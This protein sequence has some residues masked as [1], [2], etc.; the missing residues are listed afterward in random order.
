MKITIRGINYDFYIVANQTEFY[1]KALHLNFLRFSFINNLNAIL[2]EFGIDVNDKKVS[3]SQW[4]TP[5]KQSNLF[6]K[7]AVSFLSDV[8]SRNYIERKLDE[9]RRYGEWENFIS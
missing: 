9:D 3:E 2:S 4:L 8:N 5:K 6:Y 7:K 1:I